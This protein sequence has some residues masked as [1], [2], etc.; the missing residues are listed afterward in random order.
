MRLV[1]MGLLALTACS[2]AELKGPAIDS[3]GGAAAYPDVR[4]LCDGGA[5]APDTRRCGGRS[6]VEITSMGI[7][8]VDGGYAQGCSAYF[9]SVDCS[10]QGTCTCV[11]GDGGI[12]EWACTR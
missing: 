4:I 11:L 8:P 6:G 7:A 5:P 3:E 10:S 12:A 2:T 1:T 9:T